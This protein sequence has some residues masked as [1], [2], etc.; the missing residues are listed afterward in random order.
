MNE[1]IKTKYCPYCKK[2]I[3]SGAINCIHCLSALL[4]LSLKI[5]PAGTSKFQ[6][7]VNPKIRLTY[8]KKNIYKTSDYQG[9]KAD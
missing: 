3:K 8:A 5:V 2:D 6:H 4:S 1:K 9:A 7:T